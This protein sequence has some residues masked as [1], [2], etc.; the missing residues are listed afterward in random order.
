MTR[1]PSRPAGLAA[2]LVIIA[3]APVAGRVKTRL[4][5]PFTLL[6][7]AEL[8]A[9]ALADTLAAAAQVPVAGRIVALAGQPGPWLPASGFEV[10]QQRGNGLDERIAAALDDAHA[11]RPVPAVLIGMDTPQVT[12]QLLTAAIGPL[13][14]GTADAVYGPA[15]DGGFWLLG[16][17]VPD[18]AL[19]TG[20]PMSMPDTGDKLLARLACAGLRV[21]HMPLRRDVDGAADVLSVAQQ[22]PGSRFAAT[23]R[24]MLAEAAPGTALSRL[25]TYGEPGHSELGA[26]ELAAILAG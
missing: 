3:K 15:F 24:A 12:P 9:A 17:Q 26:G 14:G 2:Q 21:H 13:T 23:M 18:P 5:P 25:L 22:L 6:Q 7:A 8:A 4:T 11:R 10:I 19:I 1:P 20:V 16:L